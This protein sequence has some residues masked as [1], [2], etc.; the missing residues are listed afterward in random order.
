[1]INFTNVTDFGPNSGENWKLCLS[2]PLEL[3]RFYVSV[4]GK[5]GS[6]EQTAAGNVETV[7]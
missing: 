2:G 5:Q 3:M 1:M 4:E 6:F 7:R